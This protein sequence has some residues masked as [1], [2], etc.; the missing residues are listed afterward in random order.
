MLNNKFSG[1]NILILIFF[2]IISI[3]VHAAENKIVPIGKIEIPSL[4]TSSQNL[5]SF[6]EQIFPGSSAAI[7]AAVV[8]LSFNPTLKY[9]DLTKPIQMMIFRQVDN[10]VEDYNACLILDV[11]QKTFPKTIKEGSKTVYA[12]EL[13]GK[14]V[15][16]Y[17]KTI[18][19]Q[20]KE[21][22]PANADDIDLK[23]SFLAENF[24]SNFRENVKN[25]KSDIIKDLMEKQKHRNDLEWLKNFSMF[26]DNL[27]KILNQCEKIDLNL[28]FKPEGLKITADFI[29]GNNSEF[30]KLAN[31]QKDKKTSLKVFPDK[32]TAGAGN[33]I[34]TDS[35]ANSISNIL[36]ELSIENEDSFSPE[37]SNF[38][39]KLLKIY[40]GSFR[41]FFNKLPD[42]K[43]I[44]FI[45][46]NYDKK[47]A[48]EIDLTSESDKIYSIVG[49]PYNSNATN[50]IFYRLDN[51]TITLVSGI[52][53]PKMAET[54]LKANYKNSNKESDLYFEYKFENKNNKET[55]SLET[56]SF[57]GNFNNGKLIV[58]TFIPTENLKNVT[59]K[60]EFLEN[61]EPIF[62]T[63]PAK[64]KNL[65]PKSYPSPALSPPI[66]E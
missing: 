23:V 48:A 24:F 43:E 11:K 63:K 44:V 42:D 46:F 26:L 62:E 35:T 2:L 8:A 10:S 56:L 5:S 27:E 6:A 50:N 32:D 18:L 3:S 39:E 1:L 28:N 14:V 37:I 52:L 38:S 17:D 64:K 30:K 7:G 49:N 19:D 25:L 31:A 9:F 58:V 34:L 51:E 29:P 20:V 22:Q 55:T 54:I 40:N 59:D 33:L 21:I 41:F 15:L 65:S 61:T 45:T 36:K 16:S 57:T 12:K 53:D 4:M 47:K 60:P 66:L 13:S